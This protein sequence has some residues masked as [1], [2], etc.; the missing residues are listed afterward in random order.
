MLD[1]FVVLVCK[2]HRI[3][4]F[5]DDWRLEK[6]TTFILH[7]RPM[8]STPYQSLQPVRPTGNEQTL[9]VKFAPSFSSSAKARFF[10]IANLV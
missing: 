8:L 5:L 1:A 10:L 6:A 9:N 3:D 7:G 4:N 2:P